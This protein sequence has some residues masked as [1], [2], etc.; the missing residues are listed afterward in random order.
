MYIY[1]YEC[2]THG[3]YAVPVREVGH[4]HGEWTV[5][6]RALKACSLNIAKR[7]LSAREFT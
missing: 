2:T 1:I 7:A 5:Q 3:P 6:N 4:T